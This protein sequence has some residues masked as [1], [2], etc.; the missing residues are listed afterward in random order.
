MDSGMLDIPYNFMIGDDGFVYEGR[1]WENCGEFSQ[2]NAA[3]SAASAFDS[4]DIIVVGFFG[5]F[6]EKPP[7][8]GQLATFDKFIKHSRERSG[9][10]LVNHTLLLQYQLTLS[11]P[12]VKG[13]LEAFQNKTEF[14]RSKCIKYFKSFNN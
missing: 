12:K 4:L 6:V 7:S 8:N 13:L 1:G 14:H 3:S 9:S 10:L 5:S 2:R 11:R